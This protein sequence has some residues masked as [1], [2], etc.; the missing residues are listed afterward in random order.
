[1]DSPRLA[2]EIAALTDTGRVRPVNEDAFLVF[3]V[4]RYMERRMSSGPLPGVPERTD[5]FGEVMIVADGVGGRSAGEVAS[6]SAL[7][8]TVQTILASPQWALKLD[9]PATR[10]AELESLSIRARGYLKRVNE[11]VRERAA[12]EPG[13]AGMGTTLTGAYVLGHD[14]FVL[15]VGDSRAYLRHEGRFLRVTRDHTMAQEFVD[16]GVMSE[17]DA[18]RHRLHHVLTKAIGAT[19]GELSGD[20]HHFDVA[21]GDR[22]VLCSDG[23]T[24]VVTEAEIAAILS[25]Y[26]DS[27]KACRALVDGALERGAPDNVTVIVAGFHDAPQS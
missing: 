26:P 6:G 4:G 1:V 19:E 10:E 17:A 11:Q 21:H 27:E 9:D 15:H 16:L 23:L 24:N 13:L 7:I 18:E 12:R 2:V 22:L 8:A 5:D 20:F 14:L 3:R 25:Q